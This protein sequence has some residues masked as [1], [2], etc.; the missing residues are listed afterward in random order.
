MKYFTPEAYTAYNSDDADEAAHAEDY[1]ESA[2]ES[3]R[4]RLRELLPA[5]PRSA[6]KLARI[7]LHDWELVLAGVSP[8]REKT[9]LVATILLRQ[10][11]E[12]VEITY[13]LWDEPKFERAPRL[14]RFRGEPESWLYDEI[15]AAGNNPGHFWHHILLSS[16]ATLAVPF[17]SAS[18]RTTTSFLLSS[19]EQPSRTAAGARA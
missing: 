15:D 14:W 12:I 10:G 3:Y 7:N 6:R 9:R 4:Q 17:E 18:V 2:I 11:L 13:N 8:R 16:G 19:V 5:M 1:W